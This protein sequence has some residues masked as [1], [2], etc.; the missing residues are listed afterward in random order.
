MKQYPP[1]ALVR[2]RWY[3]KA[4]AHL[5]ATWLRGT[6]DADLALACR[7]AIVATLLKERA[8][9]QKR[10]LFFQYRADTI[11]CQA[12]FLLSESALC[13]FHRHVGSIL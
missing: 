7:P 8:E 3:T 9:G 5:A 1:G 6:D 2:P 13:S 4:P 11:V 12:A 10:P